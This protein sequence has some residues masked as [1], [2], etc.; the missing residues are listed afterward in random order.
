[1]AGGHLGL[2]GCRWKSIT[3]ERP[4]RGSSYIIKL[5]GASSKL[6]GAGENR[7][8]ITKEACRGQ[9][10]KTPRSCSICLSS[11]TQPLR[12]LQHGQ[13]TI[14][15]TSGNRN[16]NAGAISGR[17]VT[18]HASQHRKLRLG[19]LFHLGVRTRLQRRVR[20]NQ[21]LSRTPQQSQLARKKMS[22]VNHIVS[23]A[24]ILSFQNRSNA[25]QVT[26][27]RCKL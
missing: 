7:I 24:N 12:D 15:R 25:R 11:D 20:R 23:F 19:T 17:E 26:N 2:S 8:R 3:E 14:L 1:M 9:D 4:V 13:C 10:A 27:F 18:E 16:K 5:G 21:L 22:P 6:G